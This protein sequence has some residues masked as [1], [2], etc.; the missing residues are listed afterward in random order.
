[1]A[2]FVEDVGE[3]VSHGGLKL[4]G[5]EREGRNTYLGILTNQTTFQTVYQSTLQRNEKNLNIYILYDDL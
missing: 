3:E 2:H 5:T 4:Q 1:M